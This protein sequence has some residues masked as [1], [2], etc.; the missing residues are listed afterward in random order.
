MS[1]SR[2]FYKGMSTNCV[3]HT[4][5]E[6]YESGRVFFLTFIRL[7]YILLIGANLKYKVVKTHSL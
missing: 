2:V 3:S 1:Q 7:L 4:L 6:I 5:H